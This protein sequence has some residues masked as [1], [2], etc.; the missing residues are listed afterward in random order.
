MPAS[1]P[2]S[3]SMEPAPPMV[4]TAPAEDEF[5][6]RDLVRE[7]RLWKRLIS[8]HL[9]GFALAGGLG[10]TAGYLY[11]Y[12][13]I[14]Q[15]T[16]ITR[17]M[18]KNDAAGGFLGVQMGG[19]SSV[20]GGAQ[21]ATPLEKAAEAI[22]SDRIAGRALLQPATVGDTT[23]LVI[24]HFIRLGR[25][26]KAWARDSLLARV[27][28]AP[29]DQTLEQLSLTQRKAFKVVKA[30]LVPLR[31]AGIVQKAYDRRTGMLTLSCVHP[32]EAF[33]IELS[34]VLYRMLGDF[35]REQISGFSGNNASVMKRKLDSI[36]GQ[37]TAVRLAGARETDKSLGLLLQQDR[38]DLK[39]LAVKEQMLTVMYAEAL[40][41]YEG[42]QFASEASVPSLTL[43]DYPYAPIRPVRKSRLRYAALGGMALL[44][45]LFITYRIRHHVTGLALGRT[46]PP[47]A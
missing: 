16:A 15:Y 35:F 38:V 22:S 43:I 14:P 44:V 42:F 31:G 19:L 47:D 40:K 20:L 36:Q 21:V 27:R 10:A 1:Q 39:A 30:M 28:F 33:A 45:L 12:R 46:T 32:N 41:N 3:G 25:L 18:L 29:Q 7:W 26:R 34:R 37:L 2:I 13:D 17:I 4:S 6:L 5:S 11:A 9:L 24:N 8:D 23:D